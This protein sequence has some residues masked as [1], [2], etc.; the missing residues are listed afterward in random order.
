MSPAPVTHADVLAALQDA[1]PDRP[2]RPGV[3]LVA[4]YASPELALPGGRVQVFVPDCHLLTTADAAVYPD[5]H[6]RLGDDL[7][8]LLQGLTRLK[9]AFRGQL[10]VWQLGDLFDIWRARGGRGDKAEVDAIVAEYAEHLGL[11][12]SGPPNGVRANLFAGNHDYAT[13]TLPE[14]MAD[15]YRIIENED[16]VSGGD[17]LILHGDAFDWIEK[18][19]SEIKSLVVKLAKRVSSGRTD[20]QQEEQDRE[21]VAEVNQTLPVGDAPIGAARSFLAG[22]RPVPEEGDEVAV[23]LVEAG[24]PRTAKADKFFEQ[25]RQTALALKRNGHDIRLVVI[26]HTHVARIIRGDRGDG[27]PFA[28]MDCGAWVGQCRLATTDP[29]IWSAQLGVLAGSEMR[30]YQ[31]GWRT[32]E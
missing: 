2:S 25:A 21:M 12:S 23:N 31:L 9:R 10:M 1:F 32:T 14:W 22:R 6:F 17:V 27:K 5:N 30:I 20:L 3:S 8:T 18:L 29:W 4:Q 11:L 26:G 19:P 13:H 28:L 24:S 7:L 15:R 16:T